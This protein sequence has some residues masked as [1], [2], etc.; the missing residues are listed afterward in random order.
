MIPYNYIKINVLFSKSKSYFLFPSSSGGVP[1]CG[2]VVLIFRKNRP[3]LRAPLLGRGWES[4]KNYLFTTNPILL[5]LLT[6]P[7]IISILQKYIPG[8]SD[9]LSKTSVCLPASLY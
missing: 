1:P 2:G 4:E 7:L 3:A 6:F 5:I 8:A 9:F